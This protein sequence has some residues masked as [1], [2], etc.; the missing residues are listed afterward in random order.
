MVDLADL[1]KQTAGTCVNVYTH[2]EMLPAHMYPELRKHKH[3]VGHFGGAWQKQKAEFAS[4]SGPVLATTNCV[5]SP[6]DGYQDR[7]F[8]TRITAVPGGKRLKTNDFSAVVAKA[9]QRDP[10]PAHSV[11]KSTVG[12][13]HTALICFNQS[14]TNG[15]VE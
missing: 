6:P 12:F 3:L 15:L 1:L 5:L 2:G 8:T 4:F 10:L 7:L 11:G 14:E 9:K 13:H